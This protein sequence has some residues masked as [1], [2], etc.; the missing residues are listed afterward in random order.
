MQGGVRGGGAG[1]PVRVSVFVWQRS[2]VNDS[3]SIQSSVI[4]KSRRLNL[5]FCRTSFF[6][7]FKEKDFTQCAKIITASKA[8][9]INVLSA[10]RLLSRDPKTVFWRRLQSDTAGPLTPDSQRVLSGFLQACDEPSLFPVKE[11]KNLRWV[12]TGKL[13]WQTPTL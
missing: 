9:F 4:S 1:V 6:T 12:S 5:G 10:H 13:W 7:W 8:T 11:Q 3:K 2:S